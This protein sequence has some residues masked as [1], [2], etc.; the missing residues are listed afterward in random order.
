[1]TPADVIR[2]VIPNADDVICEHILWGRT[3]FPFVKLTARDLY[4]AADGFRRASEHGFRLCDHCHTRAMSGKW[5]CKKC[6][7][8]L[9]RVRVE[10]S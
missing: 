3:P 8:A 10:V 9:R 7:A 2:R 4:H 5:E 1:M 6:A